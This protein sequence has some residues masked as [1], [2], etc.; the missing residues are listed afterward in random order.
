MKFC[1]VGVMGPGT[2]ELQ[3][4]TFDLRE[5][6]EAAE[7]VANDPHLLV[8]VSWAT[9]LLT[10]GGTLDGLLKNGILEKGWDTLPRLGEDWGSRLEPFL[11][12]SHWFWEKP[13]PMLYTALWRRPGGKELMCLASSQQRLKVSWWPLSGHGSRLSAGE[14][15]DGTA[16]LA[17]SW[18]SAS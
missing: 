5:W 9:P 1:S 6:R 4:E 8:F 2:Q 10:V 15:S 16:G 14:P 17:S 11:S 3:E 7:A 12:F 18:T 13:S